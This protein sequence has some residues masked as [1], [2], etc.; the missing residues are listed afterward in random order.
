M[1]RI[2]V[3]TVTTALVA[4]LVLSVIPMSADSADAADE[5][6]DVTYTLKNQTHTVHFDGPVN[7]MIVFGYAAAL[8]VMDTD[9]LDKLYACDKYADDAYAE[10][11]LTRQAKTVANL[12]SSNVDLIK[13]FI[14]QAVDDG[15]FSK[16]D[17]IVLTTMSTPAETI[18]SYLE[19]LGF[20]HI[21]FY[22]SMEEYK[23][24]IQCV[25]EIE[26]MLGSTSHLYKNMQYILDQLTEKLTDVP[27]KDALFVWYSPSS[28]WGYGNKG[29]LSVSMINAAGGNNLG[30]TPDS[31]ESIIYNKSGVVQKL[32][33]SPDAVIFLDSGYIRSYGGSVK[34]FVDDV[35]G[36]DQGNHIICVSEHAWNNY[37]PESAD[38][39]WAMAHVMHP[40]VISG[41]VPVYTEGGSD[42]N[43]ALYIGIGV[44]VAV[45]AVGALLVLRMK[46]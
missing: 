40:D 22:G 18:R 28:G 45:V 11:G 12:S 9:K 15:E 34:A 20:T 21:V 25:K 33:A 5:A 44:A 3:F 32:E 27:K 36:G 46:H 26:M 42:D 16:D 7:K 8:T 35:L 17:A 30:Y 14:V 43:T 41:D 4:M 13:S 39:V 10:K 38:G 31:S 37:C 23:D 29:S 1:K 19:G 2:F 6:F 24:I